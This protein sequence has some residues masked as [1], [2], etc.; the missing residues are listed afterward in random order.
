MLALR[1]LSGWGEQHSTGVTLCRYDP[2]LWQPAIQ[3]WLIAEC[4]LSQYEGYAVF[5]LLMRAMRHIGK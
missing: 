2:P 5:L 3:A 4:Q 1:F